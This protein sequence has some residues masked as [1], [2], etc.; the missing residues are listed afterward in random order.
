MVPSLLPFNDGAPDLVDLGQRV[1]RLHG[2]ERHSERHIGVDD[3][4]GGAAATVG[5]VCAHHEIGA[6]CG[7]HGVAERCAGF[8]GAGEGGS[9]SLGEAD[10][11]DVPRDDELLWPHPHDVLVS[12]LQCNEYRAARSTRGIH[13]ELAIRG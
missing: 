7:A 8:E 6:V 4:A 3:E 2:V 9:H 5:H 1:R 11:G 10:E 13:L 12:H